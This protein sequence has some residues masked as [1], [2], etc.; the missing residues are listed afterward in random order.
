MVIEA[1]LDLTL[2]HPVLILNPRPQISNKNNHSK[3]YS[4]KM[5]EILY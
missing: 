2:N 4:N 3:K 1:I 5:P